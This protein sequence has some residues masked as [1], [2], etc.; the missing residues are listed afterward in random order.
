MPKFDWPTV[1]ISGGRD[2][3]TPRGVAER[4]T[5]LIPDAVLVLLPTA[6]SQHSRYP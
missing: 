1:V 5:S 2:L 3:I 4:I 6:A